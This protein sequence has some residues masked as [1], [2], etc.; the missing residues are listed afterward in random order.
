[1]TDQEAIDRAVRITGVERYRWLC[2]EANRA[3][4]PTSRTEYLGLVHEIAGGPDGPDRTPASGHAPEA[5]AYPGI[6]EQARNVASAAGRVVSAV[7][8][9]EPV[10]VSEEVHADRLAICMACEHNGARPDGVRCRK[11]G[12]RGLKLW[13]ATERC[14]DDPPRWAALTAAP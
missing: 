14:R 10:K 9:G 11:C 13:L 6:L 4:P 2:S 5:G 12:C 7:V 1:M 3:S 8:H